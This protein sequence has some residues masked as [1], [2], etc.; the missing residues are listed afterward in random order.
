[1]TKTAKIREIFKSIQGEGPH[2]GERQ[3][4]VRFCSCNLK[5]GYCDT[6]F[7][8]SKSKEYTAEE[9][10]H[11]IGR[12]N[13]EHPS[14]I[15]LTGG[16]PLMSVDFLEEFLPLAKKNGHTIYLETNAT[17]PDAL[18]KIIR[19]VDVV[20]AD[21]KL[22]STAGVKIDAHKLEQFFAFSS[23][24]ELFAKIVFD[25]KITG[26]EIENAVSLAKRFDFAII[27]QPMM[28]DKGMSV[29]IDFAERIFD[30]FYSKYQNVR[31]V[32][33][34]HKFLNVR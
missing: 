28:T 8:I 31:L 14:V 26:E 23:D 3:V 7:E 29:T 1:M 24:K 4:F 32:P 12:L 27:L 17:L 21:I 20:S 16:E 34:V 11:E 9:L 2:V 25:E 19:Y 15:S 6:D 13:P 10:L 5:C 30:K 33:Q 18:L 22:E